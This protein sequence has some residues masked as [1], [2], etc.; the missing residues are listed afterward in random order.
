MLTL[1]AL[2]LRQGGFALAA[3]AEVPPGGI[4]AIVGPS[5]GGKSTLL[6]AI[7]GFLAPEAGTVR[8]DGRDLAGLPPGERPVSILFQDGNLFPHLTVAQNVGL[9]LGPRLRLSA[10]QAGRV[11]TVLSL[12]GLA[13]R[14][15]DRPG[16]LSG[17]QQS[18]AALARVLLSGRPLI[19]L[20]EPFAA[21]GP[22][23]KD[24]MLDL[25][26]GELA[27]DGRLILMV[28]H[29]PQDALRVAERTMIVA[30]GRVS[31]P[32]ATAEVMADPPPALK[33]Y[34]GR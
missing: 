4:V 8:W 16:Q 31:G 27:A 12:V 22:A 11:D 34:L 3:D 13:G 2:R 10:E 1:E 18:R 21:L 23:L 6:S 29:D 32:L 24:E 20:D 28:S 5:G 7:A 25:V 26:A 14:G 19:L 33:A 9:A 30:D 17:G 15:D